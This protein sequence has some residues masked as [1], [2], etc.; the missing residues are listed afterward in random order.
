MRIQVL[1]RTAALTLAATTLAAC[2]TETQQVALGGTKAADTAERR[3]TVE[4]PWGTVKT[5]PRLQKAEPPSAADVVFTREMIMHHRQAIELAENVR[6]H[7]GLDER[8]G[9]SARFI[10]QDQKNEI[11]T[12]KAW[13]RAWQDT[14][15]SSDEHSHDADAMPGMLPQSRVDEIAALDPP[16]TEVAF[17]RAMIEHHEGAVTMSQDYLPE[18]SNAFVHSTATHIISEQT[19]EIT[20][21]RNLLKQWCEKDGP[22][23]CTRP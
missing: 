13:L 12:M 7:E 6:R 18:Q 16:E 2:G 1:L 21:M 4:R 19:T 3:E 17:L 8:V 11:T 14:T 22:A 15:G 10:I 20:Y 5:F 23:T 9:S